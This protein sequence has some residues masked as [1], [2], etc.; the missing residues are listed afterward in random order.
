M[1]R[2]L[3]ILW[4]EIGFLE[5]GDVAEFSDGFDFACEEEAAV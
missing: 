5:A 1:R 3:W 4:V 2:G